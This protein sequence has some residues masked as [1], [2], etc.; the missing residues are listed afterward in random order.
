MGVESLLLALGEGIQ[1]GSGEG[2]DLGLVMGQVSPTFSSNI[3][4]CF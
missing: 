3:W 1:V 4:L 2:R